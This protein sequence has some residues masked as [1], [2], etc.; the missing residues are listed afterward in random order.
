MRIGLL[1]LLLIPTTLIA[2]DHL[3]F[4]TGILSLKKSNDEQRVALTTTDSIYI[5]QSDRFALIKKWKHQLTYPS[6]LGFHPT[7]D[8]LLLLQQN[9]V[10]PPSFSGISDFNRLNQYRRY[11]KTWQ[12]NPTDSIHLF[13]ITQG[14]IIQSAPGNFYVQYGKEANEMAGI[15][16]RVYRNGGFADSSEIFTQRGTINKSSTWPK[17]CRR[18][19]LDNN[20]RYL[21]ASWFDINKK[22]GTS[23][24]FSI[25]DFLTHRP[26]IE[27]KGM[28][29]LPAD[30]CFSHTGNQLAIS[31]AFDQENNSTIR[32]YD[33]SSAQLLIE[34]PEGGSQ[35]QFSA[36]E[37]SLEF[38]DTHG[39][40]VKWDLESNIKSHTIWSNLTDLFAF[41][42]VIPLQEEI[43]FTGTAWSGVP[44]TSIAFNQLERAGRKDLELFSTL[45]QP[46]NRALTD[47]SRFNLILNDFNSNTSH[48]T[49][50]FNI[51]HTLLTVVSENQLQ[52]WNAVLR[53]KLFQRQFTAPIKAF[54]DRSG[55]SILVLEARGK[56]TF[57][58]YRLHRIQLK[59]N[60][61]FTSGVL[62]NTD[63]SLNGTSPFCN[64]LPDPSQDDTW[65][66]IDGYA[67]LWQVKGK[68]LKQSIRA[69]I[70]SHKLLQQ[71]MNAD[72]TTWLTVKDEKENN[73]IWKVTAGI[74][75]PIFIRSVNDE[76][77]TA[78][79]TGYWLWKSGK[80]STIQY[81]NNDQLVRI[82]T[83]K[84]PISDVQAFPKKDQVLVQ[85]EKGSYSAWQILSPTQKQLAQYSKWIG[86]RLYPLREETVLVENNN[87]SSV[88]NDAAAIIEWS[89]PSPGILSSTNF[90]VSEKGRYV[91]LD[92]SI[93]D[94][95]EITQ[96]NIDKY[97]PAELLQDSG[98]LRWVELI[99]DRNLLSGKSRYN[100]IRLENNGLDTVWG[101][102]WHAP[103]MN[104]KTYFTETLATS[105]DRRWVVASWKP[106]SSDATPPPP[107]VWNT[108]TMESFAI[109]AEKGDYA[110]V[111][112]EDG[113][114]LIVSS[115]II[116]DGFNQKERISHYNLSPF[117][118]IKEINRVVPIG[119]LSPDNKDQYRIESRNIVWHRSTSDSIQKKKEFYSRDYLERVVYH[120][121]SGLLLAGTKQGAIH[122]WQR[123]GY[124]SPI[125]TL[126]LHQAAIVRMEVRGDRLYTLGEDGSI[127]ILNIPQQKILVQILTVQREGEIGMAL[128][129]PEGY[130]RADPGLS[131]L[132][133]FVRNDQTY[134]LSTFEYQGNRPDKVY[135]SM[136]FSDST[137]ITLLHQSWE[138]RL[139]RA[140]IPVTERP[141]IPVYPAIGWDRT[142]LEPIV[143]DSLFVL[144]TDLVDPTASACRL[145]I[146]INGVPVG[147]RKGESLS[148]INGRTTVKR[149]VPLTSGKNRISIRVV[150]EKGQESIEQEYELVY[151]PAIQKNTRVFYAG[152]GVSQYADT[153]FNLRYA[154]KDVK[155]IS[156]KLDD[157]VGVL[158]SIS[159][160]NEQAS[161][162]NILQLHEWLKQAGTDDIVILSLS[163]HGMIDSSKGFVFAPHDMNFEDPRKKG[164][165]ME[166]LE[167]ILDDIPA[168]KRLLLL[169]A[170]HS[171]EAWSEPV[172][173]SRLPMG[174][175]VTP[176]GLIK[177]KTTD[178]SAVQKQ[179]FLLMKELFS[180]L[181]R[182]NGAFM[183]SAAGST[184]FA[185]EGNQWKN[186]VF[187]RSLI[188]SLRE[189]RYRDNVNGPAKIPVSMLR[190]RIYEKVRTF[191]RGMQNPTSRQENGWWDWSF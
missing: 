46:T 123:D 167:S 74:N 22:G 70:P 14:K 153:N 64:C 174:V 136:G 56:M 105:N 62:S 4:K 45:D 97:N 3:R 44:M 121:D 51:D 166:E 189:L 12:E 24:T 69:K 68:D 156:E 55:Q 8:D 172:Q 185:F 190:K 140:G 173:T 28:T 161:K 57:S 35:L 39:I 147:N 18:L 180:D 137:F 63:T 148:L 27:L 165:S 42:N 144:Q 135:A 112:S 52:V 129:T 79:A 132:V 125:N 23:Y 106:I 38:L 26:I 92:N 113:R 146:R 184:E 134:S 100:L 171:G 13:S 116:T 111:F 159:L 108:Q 11:D 17:A 82:D 16:N 187:T 78:S 1:L 127:A 114:S 32:I 145:F 30:F 37:K 164:V 158:E 25:H 175:S 61:L 138:A 75:E 119:T 107:I 170:C 101:K 87:L 54:P 90:A 66:C 120:A 177:E 150:N 65:S 122:I 6:I 77:L 168:Q 96:I 163:G 86:A 41:E 133:H 91:L 139:R 152:V 99:E 47:T 102:T 67:T 149:N 84:G 124:R 10:A 103:E 43:L 130:Y 142:G 81:W 21:A 109:K 143:R 76:R 118:K 36:D 33:P 85:L 176:R 58:E 98:K 169:D 183:I 182:G 72:G 162:E 50:H 93:I 157:Y 71:S 60:S 160:T 186:G 154:A 2:Q 128:Y 110:A 191:T 83:V 178:S 20:T 115:Y 181:T 94:L 126:P 9:N 29:E 104:G 34:I 151:L 80:D 7:N 40:W 141:I 179:A 59:D 88:K 95:K 15:L 89:V 31:G 73:A 188:E 19:L 5:Y 48:P 49:I 53:K 131:P 117:K 155:D